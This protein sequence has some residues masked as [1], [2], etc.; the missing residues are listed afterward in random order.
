MSDAAAFTRRKL[1]WIERVVLD[2]ELGA[3]A[4][5][6]AVL[7]AV[8]FLNS[9]TRTAWPAVETLQQALNTDRRS[10]QR[11]LKQL[12]GRGWLERDLVAGRG[13]TN[14]YRIKGGTDA[15]FFYC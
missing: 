14:R 4:V 13:H 12:E 1:A 2:G 6:I 11:A 7:L 5:R 15:A 3:V 9:T 10:V 8:K